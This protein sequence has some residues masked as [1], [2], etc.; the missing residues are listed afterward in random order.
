GSILAGG[1]VINFHGRPPGGIVRINPATGSRTL[2]SDYSDPAYGPVGDNISNGMTLSTDGGTVYA[3]SSTRIW[4]IN[5]STGQRTLFSD[6]NNPG[7][8]PVFTYA[9]GIITL[10][11]RPGP[12][13]ILVVDPR[14][15]TNA[16][17]ALFVVNPATGG[18]FIYQ[19]F[20]NSTQGPLG[21]R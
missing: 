1:D 15:G 7:Q 12:G 18:R 2:L 5:T 16:Q 21:R 10:R 6:L 4:A 19:D 13:D 3:L 14:A 9:T 8:G 11:A 20:G 17:G